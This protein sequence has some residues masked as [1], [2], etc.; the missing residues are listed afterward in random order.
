MKLLINEFKGIIWPNK[1]QVKKELLVVIIYSII[2][3]LFILGVNF[4]ASNFLTLLSGLFLW[5]IL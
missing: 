2:G 5:L 1:K 4:L 3:L